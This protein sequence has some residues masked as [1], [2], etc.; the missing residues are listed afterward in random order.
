M[1]RHV[2]MFTWAEGTSEAQVAEL[3][4]AL[5]DLP[6]LISELR[7]Y[8][9]GSDAGLAPGNW[10]FVVVAD[11]DDADGWRAY[12]DHPAHQRVL[13]KL[14]RPLLGDRAAIQFEC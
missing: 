2:A 9:V 5:R 14:L 11:V 3:Q 10:D 8:R 13:V 4:R 7:D 6:G 1:L 12:I